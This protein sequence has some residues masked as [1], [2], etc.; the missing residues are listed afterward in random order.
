M[1]R[2]SLWVWIIPLGLVWPFIFFLFLLYQRDGRI[3]ADIF[4]FPAMVVPMSLAAG[5]VWLLLWAR[6]KR[7]AQ[8]AGIAA[9][10]VLTSPFVFLMVLGSALIYSRAMVALFIFFGAATL[11]AGMLVGY[12]L[13][14]IFFKEKGRQEAA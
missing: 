7:R 3:E 1:K 12:F 4:R 6:A 2:F 9:G 8:K 14:G 5:A 11:A 10:Y 13:A